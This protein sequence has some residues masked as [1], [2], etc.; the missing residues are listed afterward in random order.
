MKKMLHLL[1]TF[2]LF[3]GIPAAS[4]EVITLARAVETGLADNPSIEAARSRITQ[5]EETVREAEA[6]WYPTLEASGSYT[7]NERS[8]NSLEGFPESDKTQETYSTGLSGQWVLFSGFERKYRT[9]AARL[10]R[11]GRRA[12]LEDAQ[13][14]LVSAIADTYFSAQLALKNREIAEADRKFNRE[15]LKEAEIK[16]KVGTGALSDLYNFQIK[17]NTAE[18]EIESA[19]YQYKIARAALA[20]L[21]GISAPMA[22]LPEPAPLA[23]EKKEEMVL[24]DIAVY[25]DKALARRPD[26]REGELS[27][28]RAEADIGAAKA[29]YWPVVSLSGGVSADRTGSATVETDDLAGSVMLGLSYPMF[30]G[31]KNQAALYRAMAVKE[32]AEQTLESLETDIASEVLQEGSKVISFQKQLRLQRENTRLVKKTRDLVESE[33]RAGQTSLVRLNE[34]QTELITARGRLALALVNLRQAWSRLKTAA[35]ST[36]I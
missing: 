23:P 14:V 31:G 17:V 8:D 4:G 9:M 1:V 21:L 5:A 33:Y 29:A 34:A 7:R 20:A 27:L 30:Q 19:A 35:G 18:T 16:K 28:K 24:P 26:I 11:K 13:R 22:H 12:S 32:E 36:E 2:V 10:A 25:T 6:L 15:Q 3:A